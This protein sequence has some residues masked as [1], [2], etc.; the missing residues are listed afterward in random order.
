MIEAGHMNLKNTI[1]LFIAFVIASFLGALI[2]GRMDD[3]PHERL[4]GR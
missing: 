4:A 3:L 1:L 2:A